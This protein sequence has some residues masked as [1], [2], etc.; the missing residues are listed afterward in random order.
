MISKR[1]RETTYGDIYVMAFASSREGYTI[2]CRQHP[3][4]P[5]SKSPNDTHLYADGHICVDRSKF[6]PTTLDQAKAVAF[7]WMTAFSQYIR[8]GRFPNEA[9]RVHV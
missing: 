1:Y 9:K 4:N 2:Y 5:N 3:P 6:N 8:T 7:A